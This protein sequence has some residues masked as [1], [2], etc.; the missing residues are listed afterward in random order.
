M[1]QAQVILHTGVKDIDPSI[2]SK[3]FMFMTKVQ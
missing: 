2:R 3:T 1:A